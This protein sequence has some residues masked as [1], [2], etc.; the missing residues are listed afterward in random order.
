MIL[1]LRCVDSNSWTRKV[2][3]LHRS[4]KA[5]WYTTLSLSVM[6]VWL[7][8]N[9]IPVLS[10][11]DTT[12]QVSLHLSIDWMGETVPEHPQNSLKQTGNQH[13]LLNFPLPQN[14]WKVLLVSSAPSP[15]SLWFWRMQW[16]SQFWRFKKTVY[17]HL[18]M[19]ITRG[20]R[21]WCLTEYCL[22]N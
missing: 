12:V 19:H 14:N 13:L 22:M 4:F 1:W 2:P 8:G 17:Q 21:H 11:E 16:L 3:S 6:H 20:H 7:F 5:E 10:V 9:T 18:E 15:A